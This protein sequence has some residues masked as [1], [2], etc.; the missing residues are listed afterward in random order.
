MIRG[1][2]ALPKVLYNYLLLKIRNVEYTSFPEI[3]G[4]IVIGGWGIL[5]LGDNLVVNSSYRSNP[6]GLQ[7]RTGFFIRQGA[8]MILGNDVGVSNSVFYAWKSII[9]EDEVM[10]GGG[11]QIYDT[12]F[13][14]ILYED[15]ILK[16]DKKVKTA[17][18]LIKKGAFIGASSIILKGVTIGE[19]SVVAAGSVVTK[20]IP[21][22]E[23]WGGNPA[24][25]IRKLTDDE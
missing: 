15:R 22:D 2:L 8:E 21:S 12:D 6:V 5:R 17:P 4:L 24:R 25:F 20:S 7:S 3:K 1:L 13:H 11:C 16:G 10:I 23:V 9:L 14:S 18:V 19:R